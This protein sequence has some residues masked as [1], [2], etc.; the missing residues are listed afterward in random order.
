MIDKGTDVGL[1]FSGV[2]PDLGPFEYSAGTS[3]IFL[4]APQWINGNFSMQVNGLTAHGPVVVHVS[5]NATDWTPTFTNAPV[6]G[7][8]AFMDSSAT[9]GATRFY[10]A[11]EQ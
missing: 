6:S 7:S 11:E 3:P 8:L 1:L 10:R 9:N 4:A 2:R 5:T